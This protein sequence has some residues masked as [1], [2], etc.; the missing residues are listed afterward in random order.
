MDATDAGKPH[1]AFGQNPQRTS[2]LLNQADGTQ[3]KTQPETPLPTPTTPVNVYNY[4]KYYQLLGFTAKIP[5]YMF[6]GHNTTRMTIYATRGGG[7]TANKQLSPPVTGGG[8]HQFHTKDCSIN[9]QFVHHTRHN[10]THREG[11]VSN[12]TGGFHVR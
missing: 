1:G 5:L 4:G 8:R 12:Q 9:T 2:I 3:N 7:E 6:D 10:N 11:K